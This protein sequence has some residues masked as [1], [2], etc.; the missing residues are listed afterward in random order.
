MRNCQRIFRMLLVSL[1]WVVCFFFLFR[2]LETQI[3]LSCLWYS[4]ESKC[5]YHVSLG[6]IAG[7]CIEERRAI[8]LITVTLDIMPLPFQVLILSF[9]L[10]VSNLC[11][12]SFCFIN[13]S[14]GCIIK[15]TPHPRKQKHSRKGSLE[16]PPKMWHIVGPLNVLSSFQRK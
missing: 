11:F 14:C 8:F 1:R 6:G 7:C 3:I 16:T 12:Y 5:D 10:N 9:S 13:S 2:N 15:N 4:W